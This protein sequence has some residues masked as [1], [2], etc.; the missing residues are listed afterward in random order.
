VSP[1]DYVHVSVRDTG[2]GMSQET[3]AHLFEPFFTTK[4]V[5]QGTGLGLATVFGIVKQSQGYIFADSE[6]GRGAALHLI[7]PPRVAPTTRRTTG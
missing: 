6:L 3:L 2:H 1:G 5:G 7:S 4:E